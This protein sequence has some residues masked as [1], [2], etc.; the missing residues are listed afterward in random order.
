MDTLE[1]LALVHHAL[2]ENM[3]RTH[4]EAFVAARPGDFSTDL[5]T[6]TVSARSVQLRLSHEEGSQVHEALRKLQIESIP[7]YDTDATLLLFQAE[8]AKQIHLLAAC[9][10]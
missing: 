6:T 1:A 9:A 7:V 5:P 8:T 2:L 3:K 10:A 4:G